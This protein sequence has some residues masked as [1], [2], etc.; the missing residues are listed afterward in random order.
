MMINSKRDFSV[1]E[2]MGVEKMGE[3]WGEI[4]QEE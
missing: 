4:Q 1:S 3:G 2:V